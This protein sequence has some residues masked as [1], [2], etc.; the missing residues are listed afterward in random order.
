MD[1]SELLQT[2]FQYIDPNFVAET[3]ISE[4]NNIIMTLAPPKI[5]QYRKNKVSYFSS[6]LKESISQ[7]NQLLIS[8]QIKI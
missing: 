8:K 4:L 3:L 2:I 5:V 1:Q 6:D 7:N